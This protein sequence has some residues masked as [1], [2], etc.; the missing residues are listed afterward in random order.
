MQTGKQLTLG[1]P[2]RLQS[3]MSTSFVTLQNS[4]C[5]GAWRGQVCW[6][7]SPRK[8]PPRQWLHRS[9]DGFCQPRRPSGPAAC[10]GHWISGDTQSEPPLGSGGGK[11][12][13]PNPEAGSPVFQHPVPPTG[14]RPGDKEQLTGT[15]S[16]RACA[17]HPT[18]G[19]VCLS[20]HPVGSSLG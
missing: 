13:R 2:A 15:M 10:L 5:L 9:P 17:Q 4:A 16:F 8:L 18:A 6:S 7:H 3:W 12:K 20:H 14:G 11:D 19:S 1:L